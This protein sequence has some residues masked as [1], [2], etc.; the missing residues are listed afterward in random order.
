[1]DKAILV[2]TDFAA[3]DRILSILDDADLAINVAMW[4]HTPEYGDSF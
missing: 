4:L 1:M 2:T 3:G